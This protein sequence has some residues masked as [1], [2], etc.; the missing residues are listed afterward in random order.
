M[1]HNRAGGIHAAASRTADACRDYDAAGFGSD[2]LQCTRGIAR[3]TVGQ[4][5][6]TAS[7]SSF[8][9]GLVSESCRPTPPWPGTSRGR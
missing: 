2:G 5:A 8:D 1:V 7:V 6:H 3:G 4:W 9:A